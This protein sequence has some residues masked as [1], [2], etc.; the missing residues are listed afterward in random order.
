MTVR[1]SHPYNAGTE[2]VGFHPPGRHCLH[3]AAKHRKVFGE[4][5]GRVG[6][7][8]FGLTN[9]YDNVDNVGGRA[10]VWS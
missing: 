2:H 3:Q 6:V 10:Q 9:V 5:H 7:A 1:P 4:S 8:A